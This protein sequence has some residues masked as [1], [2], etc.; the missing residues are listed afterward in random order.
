LNPLASQTNRPAADNDHLIVEQHASVA[1]VSP[2]A[3]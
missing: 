1:P 2:I 3:D